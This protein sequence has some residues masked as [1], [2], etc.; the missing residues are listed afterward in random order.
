MKTEDNNRDQG[1][2]IPMIRTILSSGHQT[3]VKW[4]DNKYSK[5]CEPRDK[6]QDTMVGTYERDQISTRFLTNL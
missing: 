5:L 2:S 3:S 4:S 6:F 1:M